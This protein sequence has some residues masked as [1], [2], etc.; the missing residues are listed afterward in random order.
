[1][2]NGRFL[3]RSIAVS[4]QLSKV[5]L[6]ADYLFTKC[7][8][9]LDVDGRMTGN[10]HLV[11]TVAV[12][13]R[14]ELDAVRIADLLKEL[15]CTVGPEGEP[16]VRWFEIGGFRFLE[17]PGF[18]RQQ[19]GLNKKK[20]A[21]SRIP[22]TMTPGA[23]P[24]SGP[25]LLPTNSG[26]G[27]DR[28]PLRE[29]KGSEGKK[30]EVKKEKAAAAGVSYVLRCVQALNAGMRSNPRIANPREIAATTQVAV[31][32]WESLGLP[33]EVAARVVEERAA[34]YVPNAMNLQPRSLKYFDAAVKEACQKINQGQGTSEQTNEFADYA[35]KVGG[36]RAAGTV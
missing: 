6:E 15:A 21:V 35:Q 31:V 2:P 34:G 5:S 30:S 13:L 27:P 4:E 9:H 28:V 32:E 17:F 19:Q 20:E 23:V 3:S 14:T 16:L 8:P 18:D 24:V 7:I 11:K 1:M 12:P 29:V 25:D 10:P 36:K 33:V 22:S 26:P